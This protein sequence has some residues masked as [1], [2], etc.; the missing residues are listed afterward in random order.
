MA[1]SNLVLQS[2]HFGF[3][4]SATAPIASA[5]KC[6]QNHK[7][8]K[9]RTVCVPGQ[10]MWWKHTWRC[11]GSTTKK[12]LYTGWYFTTFSF[13]YTSRWNRFSELIDV[14]KDAVYWEEN[15]GPNVGG[16]KPGL[17]LAA[18]AAAAPR[19][20]FPSA[21]SCSHCSCCFSCCSF[22]LSSRC[23]LPGRGSRFTF[24]WGWGQLFC[25]FLA[26][27]RGKGH[28]SFSS[29]VTPLPSQCRAHCFPSGSITWPQGCSPVSCWGGPAQGG[30][31]EG[32]HLPGAEVCPEGED[33]QGW[34]WWI[35]RIL[36]Q[37]NSPAA[38]HIFH[39]STNLCL[40]I[41]T[42]LSST[43]PLTKFIGL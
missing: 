3:K 1:Q 9:I 13:S 2:W 27:L 22:P 32:S 11:L 33:E 14:P 40:F 31:P 5:T 15:P 42:K 41:A 23:S 38:R 4:W 29:P 10:W 17:F 7:S 6:C 8:Q 30:W 28:C 21:L 18:S 26:L 36:L 43:I 20:H 19:F 35:V 12:E 34:G 16:I 24:P 39:P 37:G 25:A